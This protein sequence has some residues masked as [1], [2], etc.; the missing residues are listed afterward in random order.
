MPTASATAADKAARAGAQ[1]IDIPA[2]RATG[3]TT[4]D[5]HRAETAAR[6]YLDRVDVT[7]ATVTVSGSDVAVTVSV[8]QPMRILPVP[9]RTITATETATA[10]DE[11]SP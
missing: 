6:D 3:E 7:A 11:A 4:L 10:L 8:S 1:E 5:P 9:D 2:L